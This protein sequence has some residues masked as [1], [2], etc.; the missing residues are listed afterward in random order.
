MNERN[1]LALLPNQHAKARNQLV[2]VEQLR[3]R[4]LKEKGYNLPDPQLLSKLE[5]TASILEV[6]VGGVISTTQNQK[7]SKETDPKNSVQTAGGIQVPSQPAT[8]SYL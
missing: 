6:V 7:P 1:A 4:M 2:R 8:A 3:T 5:P